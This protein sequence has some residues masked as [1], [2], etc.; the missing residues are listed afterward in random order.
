MRKFILELLDRDSWD[1]FYCE[2]GQALAQMTSGDCKV[3]VLGCC[4]YPNG[5]SLL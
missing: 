5:C 2:G 3:F 4:E 1:F